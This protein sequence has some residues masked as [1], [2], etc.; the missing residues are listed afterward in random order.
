MNIYCLFVCLFYVDVI[1][2]NRVAVCDFIRCQS[3]GQKQFTMSL[4]SHRKHRP[5]S[6]FCSPDTCYTSFIFH[7]GWSWG[8]GGGQSR[9]HQTLAEGLG[10]RSAHPP[11]GIP[12][13]DIRTSAVTIHRYHHHPPSLARASVAWCRSE[14][15]GQR[16]RCSHPPLPQHPWWFY[17]PFKSNHFRFTNPPQPLL[18]AAVPSFVH[19][20]FSLTNLRLPSL[21]KK[22]ISKKMSIPSSCPS[23]PSPLFALSSSPKGKSLSMSLV[24]FF[25]FVFLLPPPTHTPILI[26]VSPSCTFA[27]IV[28]SHLVPDIP[29]VQP[30]PIPCLHLV[31]IVLLQLQALLPI[32]ARRW[33]HERRTAVPL[34]KLIVKGSGWGFESALCYFYD[35]CRFFI[36]YFFFAPFLI[37]FKQLRDTYRFH[38]SR[39]GNSI[40]LNFFSFSFSF[41]WKKN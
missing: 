32:Q 26:W 31:E 11:A 40:L 13:G 6:T 41:F 2:R 10:G 7:G 3:C 18:S 20:H 37:W 22:N 28:A 9:P 38:R 5:L 24:C 29:F 27:H 16:A 36:F 35:K 17:S 19:L 39:R 23:L 30:S 4:K 34:S 12:A 14:V 15:R 21:P 1:W 8:C 33:W 25:L